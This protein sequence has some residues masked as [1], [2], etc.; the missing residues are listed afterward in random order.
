MCWLL[1]LFF[2]FKCKYNVYVFEYKFDCLLTLNGWA[3]HWTLNTYHN[4]C[5]LHDLF[6]FFFLFMLL[7]YCVFFIYVDLIW[8]WCVFF[9]KKKLLLCGDQ[10]TA[11]NFSEQFQKVQIMSKAKHFGY[12]LSYIFVRSVFLFWAVKPLLLIFYFC[13]CFQL[14]FD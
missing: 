9:W 2:F 1:V 7:L 4:C 5:H 11:E 13:F 8:F 3:E 6:F 12:T 10:K 14:K